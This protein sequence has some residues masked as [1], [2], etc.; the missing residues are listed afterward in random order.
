MKIN[1]LNVA[2]LLFDEISPKFN[3][4]SSVNVKEF[5]LKDK[6]IGKFTLY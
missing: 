6:L 5:E 4:S 3:A 2:K 1:R